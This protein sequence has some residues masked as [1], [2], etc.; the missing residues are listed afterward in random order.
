MYATAMFLSSVGLPT[1]R[2]SACRLFR[3]AVLPSGLVTHDAI[4]R[5]VRRQLP[6][7]RVRWCRRLIDTVSQ[8]GQL[9]ERYRSKWPAVIATAWCQ[10]I[11]ARVESEHAFLITG[12]DSSSVSI[13][14]PLS[15][16]PAKGKAYNASLEEVAE[17]GKN[18]FRAEA[19]SW[20]VDCGRPISLLRF[21]L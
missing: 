5:V 11:P 12:G 19:G 8:L 20:Q 2:L 17:G 6:H 7:L 13:L 3:Q 14:D 15:R 16:P 10:Y 1:D 21:H 18:Y 9:S 4:A